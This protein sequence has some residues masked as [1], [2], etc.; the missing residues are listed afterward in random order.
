MNRVILLLTLI[1]SLLSLSSCTKKEPENDSVYTINEPEKVFPYWEQDY[2]CG[3]WTSM[4]FEEAVNVKA[5]DNYIIHHVDNILF[6]FA[7]CDNCDSIKVVNFAE[8]KQRIVAYPLKSKDCTHQWDRSV[9]HYSMDA[10]CAKDYLAIVY[11]K[12]IYLI[13]VVSFPDFNEL[14]YRIAKVSEKS[15]VSPGVIDL[16]KLKWD[17]HKT[18]EYQ[19]EFS[20][21]HL[22]YGIV[23]DFTV[24]RYVLFVGY[25]FFYGGSLS[26][27]P[28][29]YTAHIAIIKHEQLSDPDIID[30]K[31]YRFKCW[32]DGLGPLGE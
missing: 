11:G 7:M 26:N 1:L 19:I 9:M 3:T 21:R 23:Y 6:G 17:K 27:F 20:D 15:I 32:E 31:R 14:K 2:A 10:L 18:K 24:S 13:R 28:P 5:M 12:K 8:K 22:I 4:P 16:K 29:E 25:D 30:L